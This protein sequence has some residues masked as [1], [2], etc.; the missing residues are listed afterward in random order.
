VVAVFV[1][2]SA[3]ED[4][5]SAISVQQ[6]SIQS[7]S[8]FRGEV[9]RASPS[10]PKE[11]L[12]AE[13]S[14]L[15]GSGSNDL[16]TATTYTFAASTDTL[17][18]M[19]TGTTTLVGA[20]LDDNASAVTSI[21][22][23]FWYDGVRF[24][25]FSV[26][27]NG[28]ARLGG[29][30]ITT[31]FDN[32]TDFATTTNAPKI[33]PYYDDLWTGTNGKVHSK[34]VGTAPS[35]K[36][37]VEWQNEQIPR[38]GSGN[39]GAGT[40]QMW[41]YE[42][43][44]ATLPGVIAFVYGNGVVINSVQGG[45]TVGLQSGA[46]T[47]FASVTTSAG[48]VSYAA[49]NNT[50]TNAIAAGTKY[51]FTPNVPLAPTGLT[52]GPFTA[53]SIQLNWTD[54]ATNEV[55]Y[56]I[57]RSLDGVTYT[58]LT[59]LAA[60]AASFN[61][62]GLLPGTNYFYQVYAVTEGA[63][64]TPALAGSQMTSPPGNVTSVATGNWNTGATWSSGLVPTAS[65]NVTIS[66][67]H[68][69]TIDTN[70]VAFNLTIGSTPFASPEG[71]GAVLQ[72][73]GTARTV[74]IGGDVNV[75]SGASFT[76][77]A[78]AILTHVLNIGGN[79]AGST[80]AGNLLVNGVFDMN[81]TAGVTTNFFGSTNGTISGAGATC[82]FFDIDTNKGSS[83][84]PILDVT[85]TITIGA[86]A[87]SA[88][89]LSAT[90]GT[91]RLS[92]ASVLTPWFGSQTITAANGRLWLND[93]GASTTV[94]GVGTGTGAGAPTFTGGLRVDAGTFGYGSGNNTMTFTGT[95]GSLV[96]NGGTINMFGAVLFS[97]NSSMTMTAGN[98]N[99]D[100]QASNSLAATTNI[101]RF[102][103]PNPVAFTGGTVTIID[104][105]A[106]TGSGVAF[107]I[108]TGTAVGYNFAGSTIRFGNGVSTTAGSAD[109]FDLDTFVGLALVTIGNVTVDNTATNAATRFVRAANALAPFTQ[110][111]GGNLNITATG[112]SDFRLNGHLVGVTG[113]II[114]NGTLNGTVAS[115][116]LYFL[117]AGS[118]QTYS[119]TGT[120]IAP[121]I[122]F[123]VDNPL[124]VTIDPAVTN[125]VTR[126]IVLFTGG[127]T[128]SNKLT[129]GNGDATVSTFQAGNSSTPTAA[130]TLDVPPVFNLGTGGQ[131]NSYMR[132]TASYTT[133]NEINPT[134]TLVTLTYDD[135][136]PTHTLTIA[137][138]D[139]TVSNT[140]LALALT[141]GRVVTGANTLILAS[142]TATVTR[143]TGLVDGNLRKT[144]TATGNKTF[145]VG[146]ANGYS[147]AAIN[148]TTLT[149]NPSTI[150]LRAVQGPHPTLVPTT[151]LQRYWTVTE[152]G[153][154]TATLTF[155]YLDPL[156]IMG[157]EA[158]YRVVKVEGGVPFNFPEVC[159]A[160]PCVDETANTI[161][162]PGVTSF[163][164]WTAAEPFAPTAIPANINGRVVTNT[165]A[166]LAGVTM[167]LLDTILVESRTTVTDPNGFYHF[168]AILTGRDILVTPSRNGFTFNPQN[169]L[170]NHI[171][172]LNN[173]DFAGTPD[174]GQVQTVGN[175]YDGD[176]MAD[177][178]VF[179][180]SEATWYTLLS[181][182]GTLKVQQWGLGDDRIVPADYDGDHV[183]D[184]AVFRPSNG[185]WY[186]NL[187]QSSTLRSVNWGLAEDVVTPA[188]FDGDGMTDIAVWRP[189]TGTWYIIQSQN[190]QI[191]TVTW[192]VNG[193]RPVAA[194]YDGDGKADIAVWR[195]SNGV[196][197]VMK[198]DGSYTYEHWGIEE[199]RVVVGDYDGDHKSDLAVFR[200]S[201]ATWYVK[202]SS[203]G[204]TNA[205]GHGTA[206]DLLTPG[207]YDGD[208]MTDRAVW[209]LSGN[210]NILRSTTNTTFG[211]TWGTTGDIPTTSAYVR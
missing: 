205:R 122:S 31:S 184:V 146:T 167:T 179:R 50:Q 180:P 54:M 162:V 135:N 164:D 149:T 44:H 101:F 202:H 32:S 93:A 72:Y 27:A 197:Y 90:N 68:T 23:D 143:T 148:V 8:A 59:Q 117:G 178:T 174:S 77:G 155:N 176:G 187:S 35:R 127:V 160:G 98:I 51:T 145:E 96:M 56:V 73:D 41:L 151:S 89:R 137:G 139:L 199:D 45:Y 186:I 46:A 34:V 78:S 12:A 193:D 115:S 168:N 124:G 185:T 150:T 181:A 57:Y 156:D 47:N 109:G 111:Y 165:G 67:G 188:D 69:V 87:A 25:Q 37:V 141:N 133:G 22:F 92:S 81:T 172:E 53:S 39:A 191:R 114:N 144:Y 70:A 7:E 55:G 128:N 138:G 95:T 71:G 201:T 18:D 19:T 183:T 152:G 163:S 33:A 30:V 3:Q 13:A 121:L 159:P 74:T 153:D 154:A 91:F 209:Q 94:V 192:G 79:T 182:T 15:S 49:A 130:G 119:G 106:A 16:I 40:F 2:G 171:G 28:L 126:R 103:G 29:T 5:K 36:L 66:D 136:D 110:L 194:D 207:D 177:L 131:S 86:P 118:A 43:S 161:V 158:T 75:T 190:G 170:F 14:D 196:W 108:S 107:S 97:A 120:S 142:G 26:N 175:D 63:L 82:D 173:V 100:P 166:P 210:W 134:R 48:T 200:P 140:A 60:N 21:G 129:L 147:P 62:T 11:P 203:D 113:N 123:E 125:I 52:F 88:N 80:A 169:R 6:E 99:V 112:G 4:G 65:D 76:A 1:S 42:S 198:I 204:S 85:R 104:P 132:T 9:R 10:D 61:D 211:T 24:T 17:E 206:L 38:V 157:N 64:S 116:R 83:Q 105:H 102:T 189:S 195:P 208:G 84:T 20:N 58:F